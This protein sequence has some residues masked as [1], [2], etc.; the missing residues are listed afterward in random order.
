MAIYSRKQRMFWYKYCYI[1][2]QCYTFHVYIYTILL[3]VVNLILPHNRVSVTPDHYPT[4]VIIEHVIVFKYTPS[5]IKH[6]DPV[7]L[8]AVHLWNKVVVII[9][10]IVIVIVI[11][12]IVII[13]CLSLISNA[14]IQ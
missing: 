3:S 7:A 1:Y 11:I 8:V 5:V 10:I 13:I 9:I 14:I 12:I 4:P 2:R 6:V